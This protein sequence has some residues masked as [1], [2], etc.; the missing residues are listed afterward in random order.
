MVKVVIG[1]RADTNP[2]CYQTTS[3][4]WALSMRYEYMTI[5]DWT[6]YTCLNTWL[7]MIVQFTHAWIHDYMYMIVHMKDT[8][9]MAVSTIWCMN[10]YDYTWLFI[11]LHVWCRIH[12]SE[13]YDTRRCQEK[14]QLT[15]ILL[16][17]RWLVLSPHEIWKGKSSSLA[18]M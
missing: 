1:R 2:N 16:N 14:N 11:H 6:I 3:D 4:T 10:T 17:L 13:H 12:G 7:Y 8:R 15:C 9:Y 18:V 5:R